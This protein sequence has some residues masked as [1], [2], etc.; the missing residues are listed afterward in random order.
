MWNRGWTVGW[1]FPLRVLGQNS[2]N[3]QGS[4]KEVSG[5]ERCRVWA[6][7][8]KDGPGGRGSPGDPG[9]GLLT[10]L[11]VDSRA[12][13]GNKHPTSCLPSVCP[14]PAVLPTSCVD[15]LHLRTWLCLEIGP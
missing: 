6:V 7:L 8:A 9:G 14:G 12:G 2:Q 4:E 11:G 1:Q 3:L 13:A 10:A 5:G 15:A